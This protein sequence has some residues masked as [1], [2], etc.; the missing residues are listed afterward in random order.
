MANKDKNPN[1][2]EP[3]VFRHL[4]MNDFLCKDCTYRGKPGEYKM[5]ECDIYSEKPVTVYDTDGECEDYK[6]E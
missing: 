1:F 4:S 5:T 2:D 6:K 3:L